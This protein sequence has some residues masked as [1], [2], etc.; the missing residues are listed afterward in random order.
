MIPNDILTTNADSPSVAGSDRVDLQIEG[1]TCASCVARIERVLSRVPGVTQASV[2]LATERASI[3]GHALDPQVL[4]L[5]I[6]KAG[7]GVVPSQDEALPQ[8]SDRP[9]ALQTPQAPES[10]ESLQTPQASRMPKAAPDWRTP[11][12]LILAAPLV[13]PMLLMPLGVHWMPAAWVQFALATP[14][15][16]ILGAR[17]YRAGWHALRAGT[18]NM[19]LL[20]AVGT[21]AAWALSMWLWW[22]AHEGHAPHLYFESSAVVIALVLLGKSLEARA[23]RQTTAAIRALSALRPE[24]A[25]RRVGG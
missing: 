21:S 6:E 3:L 19:E 9:Q 14:V 7:Y 18:G 25:R 5:A 10:P 23:K 1:M 15:Q 16:F 13:L 2:N 4:R 11:L 8:S 20:V 17:F 24:T 22:R 12:A